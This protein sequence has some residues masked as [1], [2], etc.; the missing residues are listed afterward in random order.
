[1]ITGV[2]GVE[3]AKLGPSE[4]MYSSGTKLR[5]FILYKIK[6]LKIDRFINNFLLENSTDEERRKLQ[7]AS[8]KFI[9]N[10]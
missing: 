3:F 8:K 5:I 4:I 7:T 9:L 2:D 10:L 6:L 1:M